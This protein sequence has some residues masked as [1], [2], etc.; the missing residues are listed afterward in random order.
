MSATPQPNDYLTPQKTKAMSADMRRTRS[1]TATDV[2]RFRQTGDQGI[3]SPIKTAY[4]QPHFNHFKDLTVHEVGGVKPKPAFGFEP[5]EIPKHGHP[6]RVCS[7]APG[8]SKNIC[9]T[10]IAQKNTKWKPG[11]IYIEHSDWRKNI[12]FGKFG[13]YTMPKI[14]FTD[15]QM[16]WERNRRPA[17]PTSYDTFLKDFNKSKDRPLGNFKV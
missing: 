7:F 17:G 4:N 15:E 10:D 6:K 5:F 14:T 16:R 11:P 8:K 9:F 3:E 2:S 13:K 1:H 12:D